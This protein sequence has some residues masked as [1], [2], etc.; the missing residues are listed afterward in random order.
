MAAN[1][2]PCLRPFQGALVLEEQGDGDAELKLTRAG[3]QQDR[4]RCPPARA[5]GRHDD[6]GVE[7]DPPGHVIS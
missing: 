3:S 4:R 5:E 6:I 2:S 1:D 7:H